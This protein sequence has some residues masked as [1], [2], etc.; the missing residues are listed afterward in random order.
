MNGFKN[1]M[2]ELYEHGKFSGNISISEE[3]KE[4]SNYSYGYANIPFMVPVNNETIFET[5]SVTKTFTAVGIMKLYEEGK[6]NI[7]TPVNVI[8]PEFKSFAEDEITIENLLNHTSG[9]GDYFDEETDT[10]FSQLWKNIPNYSFKNLSDF[11]TLFENKPKK[12]IC[13][14]KFSYNNAGYIILGLIIEKITGKNYFEYIE[15]EICK[16]LPNTRFIACDD[17]YPNVAEGYDPVYGK[18]GEIKKLKKVIYDFPAYGSADGG[19]Y[20]TCGELIDFFK[21]LFNGKILKEETVKM[22]TEKNIR[23]CETEKYIYEYGFGLW[24]AYDKKGELKIIFSEGEDPGFSARIGYF[25]GNTKYVAVLSNVTDGSGELFRYISEN[26]EYIP[27]EKTGFSLMMVNS[28]NYTDIL[29]IKMDSEQKEFV[30][31][32]SVSIAESKV[33]PAFE[34]TA[35]CIDGKPIGYMMCKTEK[36]KRTGEIIRFMIKKEFQGKGYGKRALGET[37]KKMQNHGIEKVFLSYVPGNINAETLYR[38]SGFVKTGNI[39]DDEIE[40]VK[41][42]E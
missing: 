39:V 27:E 29:R 20:S 8:I 21:K 13:G 33:F 10:D 6:I 34:N 2:R 5:A 11:I 42:F 40:M 31:P 7:E 26:T 19:I 32:N 41:V 18:N 36:E 37:L 15:T 38:K 3:S 22:M 4:I 28:D 24:K 25:P 35:I 16:E 9:I 17:T 1:K 23:V 12:F 30:A 14:E